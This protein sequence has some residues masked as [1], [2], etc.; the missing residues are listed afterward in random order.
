[1]L[2]Y[3]HVISRCNV[4][5]FKKTVSSIPSH[6]PNSLAR[7]G[8]STM[9]LQHRE[10]ERPHPSR[11]GS[12]ETKPFPCTNRAN[13]F[14][15]GRPFPSRAERCLRAPDPM[16]PPTVTRRTRPLPHPTVT[17]SDCYCIRSSPHPT[18]T[19]P[20]RYSIRPLQHPTFTAPDR[21]RARPLPHPTVIASDRYH[22]GPLTHPTCYHPCLLDAHHTPR[23]KTS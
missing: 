19:A 14:S 3:P 17:V 6:V 13:F 11:G 4:I 16:Y 23:L 5:L 2:S 21:Y 8:W 1:M 20:D 15:C 7:L 10:G 12:G 22:I 18:V 9:T